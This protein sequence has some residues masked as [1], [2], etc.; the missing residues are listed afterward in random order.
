M[1]IADLI[2]QARARL[3]NLAQLRTSA[4]R[5]GDNEQLARIDSEAAQTQ[6]TLNELLSLQSGQ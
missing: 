3:V 5:L 2:A 4:E 1:T 6:V